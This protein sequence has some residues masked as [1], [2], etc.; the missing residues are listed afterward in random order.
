[1]SSIEKLNLL[2]H[3]EELKDITGNLLE[4]HPRPRVAVVDPNKCDANCKTGNLIASSLECPASISCP[5]YAF[6][7]K[8]NRDHQHINGKICIG[9]GNCGE[10]CVKGA[11][12]FQPI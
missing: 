6:K 12:R 7:L 9:C 5:A 1:V 2:F 3:R 8:E 10:T 4:F 11:I